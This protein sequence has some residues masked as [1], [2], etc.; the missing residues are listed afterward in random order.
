MAQHVPEGQ[1]GVFLAALYQ[2]IYTHQQGITSMVVAQAGI[3]VHL[4]VNNWATTASMTQL[5]AQV[6][7]GQGSLHRCTMASKQIEYTPIAP[8]GCTMVSTSLFPREQVQ[9]E[10]TATRP[11]YLGNETDSGLSSMGRSIPIKT[12]ARGSG[13]HCQPLTSTSKPKPKLLVAAQQH[14]DELAAKQRGAPHGAHFQPMVQQ[15][16]QSR[17]PGPELHCQKQNVKPGCS[18]NSSFVSVEEHSEFTTATL[19]R[20]DGPH[21]IDP[22]EDIV[23]VCDSSDIEMMSTHEY[24]LETED[25]SSNSDAEGRHYPSDGSDMES[26]QDQGSGCHSNWISQQGSGP[27]SAQGSDADSGSNNGGDPKSSDYNGGG[28]SDLF[29]VKK[30]C[31]GSSKRPQS[32][33]RSWETENQKRWHVPSL[34]NDPNSDKPDR[35]K[36]KSDRKETPS[37]TTSKKESAQEKLTQQVREEIVHKFR[38]KEENQ[39]RESRPKKHK[40]KESSLRKET[41]A[42]RDSSEEDDRR[43]Q[44]K[45]KDAKTREAWE[46]ECWAEERQREKVEDM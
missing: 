7:P 38:E 29:M 8:K 5:F 40:K 9:D 24:D 45:K 6:I 4:G 20:R 42:G 17:P 25:S 28:F 41:S 43:N 13:G 35:K 34:E 14:W 26:D 11:I 33:S 19:M 3:P 32:C 37:K 44:K 16:A 36:K 46:A 39:E 2:L 23:S 22:D 21:K 12:L 15:A 10:G 31:P 1:V 27:G 30:E 18:G